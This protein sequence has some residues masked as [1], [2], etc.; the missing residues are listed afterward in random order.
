MNYNVVTGEMQELTPAQIAQFTQLLQQQA[1]HAAVVHAHAH[2]Q[3]QGGAPSALTHMQPFNAS[4]VYPSYPPGYLTAAPPAHPLFLG[5]AAAGPR[6]HVI[7]IPPPHAAVFSAGQ[8]PS[9]LLTAGGGSGPPQEPPSGGGASPAGGGSSTPSSPSRSADV[10]TT[11]VKLFVFHIAPVVTDDM[12]FAHFAPYGEVVSARVMRHKN[13]TPRG[14]G[15]VNFRRLIDGER[16]IAARHGK[17]Y[18]G[19]RLVVSF[20]TDGEPGGAAT[21]GAAAT[22]GVS[23]E[24]SVG[25][26]TSTASSTPTAAARAAA[27]AAHAPAAPAPPRS[28][29]PPGAPYS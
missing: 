27:A 20:K 23:A 16:A 22:A 21:E 15:F 17:T 11:D 28:P 13:G 2:A 7:T 18:H 4:P 6:S 14:F 8:S 24:A 3:G 12:L 25:S 19:K 29:Q 1:N 26:S 5:A 10:R 9:A